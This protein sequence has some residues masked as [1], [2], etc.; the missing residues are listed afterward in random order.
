MPKKCLSEKLRTGDL[1]SIG[2]AEEVVQRVL[3]TPALF[4]ENNLKIFN[5][6]ALSRS[7]FNFLEAEAFR[8]GEGN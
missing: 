5:F 8:M 4:S 2:R 3:K 1:R 7:M 6:N